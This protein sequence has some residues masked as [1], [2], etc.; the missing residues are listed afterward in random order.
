MND[1]QVRWSNIHGLKNN[2]KTFDKPL[3]YDRNLC[4][5]DNVVAAMSCWS[6]EIIGFSQERQ[7][8]FR[9]SSWLQNDNLLK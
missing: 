5:L 4:I 8:M 2:W 7:E 3:T 6:L 1:N 9:K